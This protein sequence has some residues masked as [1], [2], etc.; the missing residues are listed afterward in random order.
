MTLPNDWEILL[1]DVFYEGARNCYW[2]MSSVKYSLEYFN[3]YKK[4]KEL[5]SDIGNEDVEMLLDWLDRNRNMFPEHFYRFDED[6]LERLRE[7]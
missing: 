6:D 7:L 2:W 1:Q 4:W 5:K 3:F